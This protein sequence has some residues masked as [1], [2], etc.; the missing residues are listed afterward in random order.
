MRVEDLSLFIKVVESGSFSAA[1]HSLDLPRANVSRRINEL[2]QSL[3]TRLFVRTT[4]KLNL[5]TQGQQYYESMQDIIRRLNDAN[6]ALH[7]HTASPS[8]LV[9]MGVNVGSDHYVI[10]IL[11]NF[12]QRYPDINVEARYSNES[13]Q[14]L[15]E[16]GL[17]MAMY[18]GSLDDSSF[19]ARKLGGFSKVIIASPEYLEQNPVPVTPQDLLQHSCIIYRSYSQKLENRWQFT[20]QEIEVSH[21]HI[22]NNYAHIA[23]AVE[24]GLGIAL[25]PYILAYP[26][27]EKGTVCHLMKDHVSSS[28]DAWM[29]YPSRNGLTHTARL[30]LDY[31]ASRV[32]EY[33]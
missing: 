13:Y 3:S 14:G 24:A 21:H 32:P 22:S 30:L 1:A 20:N 26:M 6:S 31:I 25:V 8:G 11:K 4:R 17:D 2:E 15:F 29:V 33:L 10:D 16:H 9:K 5:T 28:E 19:I 7:S 23:Q 27:I 12:K 18:V